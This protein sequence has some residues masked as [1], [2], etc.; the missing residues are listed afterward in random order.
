MAE[1]VNLDP[2]DS[3]VTGWAEKACRALEAVSGEVLYDDREERPGIKFKDADLVGCP[4]QVILGG[5][6]VGRGVAE[7]KNRLTGEKG[8]IEL[9]KLEQG[10]KDYVAAVNEAWSSRRP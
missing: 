6:G 7:T 8:T 4:I 9:D 5:K 2:A 3:T 1:V 10:I